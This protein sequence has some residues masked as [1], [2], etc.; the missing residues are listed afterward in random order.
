MFN[1]KGNFE[2][3]GRLKSK[4]KDRLSEKSVGVVVEIGSDYCLV[5]VIYTTNLFMYLYCLFL[6]SDFIC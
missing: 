2:W 6:V 4:D 5:Y 1:E 3:C